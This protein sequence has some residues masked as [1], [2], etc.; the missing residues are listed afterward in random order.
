MTV[1]VLVTHV[2]RAVGADADGRVPATAAD[3]AR[4]KAPELP[5]QSVVLRPH[6]GRA[7]LVGQA[8][9]A[10]QVVTVLVGNV[11]R[12][13]GSDLHMTMDSRA[14]I[15]GVDRDSGAECL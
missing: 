1:A 12:A 13:V 14:L 15:A 2:Q 9:D 7:A 10:R 6:D 4:R 3:G 11:D 8:G 5:G